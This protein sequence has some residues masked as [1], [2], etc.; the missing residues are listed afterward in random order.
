MLDLFGVV[1]DQPKEKD[2]KEQYQDYISSPK[3][4]RLRDAKIESVGGVCERCG[5]SKF[6]ARLEVHHLHYRTFQKEKP[7]DLQALCPECHAFADMERQTIESL[8]KKARQQSSSLYIGFINWMKKGNDYEKEI[9][10][11]NAFQAKQ[12]FL[13]MLWVKQGKSYALD[14]RVFGYADDDPSW[15]P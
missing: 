11:Y 1:I 9:N 5:I 14:L 15:R 4:R 12:K 8:E 3:W 7:A 6:S 2:F 13:T 10:S